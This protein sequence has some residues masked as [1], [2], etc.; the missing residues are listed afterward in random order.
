MPVPSYTLVN[1]KADV[2]DMAPKFGF[3][4]DL[5]SRFARKTLELENSG[6][7]YFRV[8]PDYRIPF[9]HRHAD[10]E[11]IYLVLS[12][13]AR[14]KLEDEIVELGQ[15]DALR[16]PAEVTR[17]LEAG[18]DGAELIAFGAPSNENAD[19]EMV[20]GWWADE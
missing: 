2:E 8:A 9:G 15:W 3:A 16:V 5:E 7:S 19:V 11:E 13:S 4:P 14:M 17:G 18:P 6:L 20:Q 12:G 10:Q 1:L